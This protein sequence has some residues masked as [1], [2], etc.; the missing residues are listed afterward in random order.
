MGN[1]KIIAD[2][3]G[4]KHTKQCEEHYWDYYLGTVGSCLPQKMFVG[5]R[6][7]DTVSCI[8]EA[9]RN[10][11]NLSLTLIPPDHSIGQVVAREKVRDATRGGKKEQDLREKI[12]HLPGAD[13][14]GYM[15]LREDFDYEYENSA[16]QI[17]ADMEF[18]ADDHA[19]EVALKLEVLKIY[20]K[21]LDERNRRK[22]FVIDRGIVD[23]KKLQQVKR[24]IFT[25]FLFLIF[26]KNNFSD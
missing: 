4:T 18:C 12:A 11:A 6:L 10:S 13:L 16:E 2:Y 5:D 26:F 24:I 20:N 14:P 22:R 17:L 23:V 7:V 15:P 21:K 1:W 8:P 25:T 3:I 19:S 9:H